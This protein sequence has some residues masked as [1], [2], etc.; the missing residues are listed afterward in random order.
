MGRRSPG[1]SGGRAP[2]A[3]GRAVRWNIGCPGTGRPGAGRGGAPGAGIGALYTGRGPVCGMIM[4]R[5][6][7]T[8]AAG[9]SGATGWTDTFWAEGCTDIGAP[10]AEAGGAGTRGGTAAVGGAALAAGAAND[11]A[12]DVSEDT[13]DGGATRAGGATGAFGGITT[14]AGGRW[15]ATDAGVTNLG[16][17]GSATG[18]GGAGLAGEGA[19][20]ASA[21]ASMEGAAT[22]GGAGGLTTGRA[23]GCSAASFCCVMARNTSPGRE[24]CDRSILVL[25]SS[26]P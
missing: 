22:D 10:A 3:D 4:R 17:G 26:S 25:N 6:G 12:K 18:F 8:G 1:R 14:T 11:D 2:G 21:L 19:A 9:L 24:M 13:D 5:G 7:G 20:G 16:A 15:A 23:T